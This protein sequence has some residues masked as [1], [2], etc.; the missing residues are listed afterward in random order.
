MSPL[1]KTLLFALVFLAVA[2]VAYSLQ[3]RHTVIITL[4]P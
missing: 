2:A 1:A 4:A 3:P